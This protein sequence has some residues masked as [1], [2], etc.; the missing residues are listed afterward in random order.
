MMD[1]K[2]MIAP[3]SSVGADEGRSPKTLCT[4]SSIAEN[5]E[6]IKSF[7][8]WQREIRRMADPSYLKTVSMTELF[9][10][11]YQSRPPVI[12]GLLCRGM[13]LF[14][15]APKVGKSFLMGQVAYHVS[16]GTPLWGFPVRQG[17]VLY[18]AL[19]DDYGFKPA[20]GI[21]QGLRSFAEWY[22]EYYGV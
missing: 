18:L 13:Y 9:D 2:R 12:D 21:R 20:I 4:D 10:N 16:T 19:E 22:R 14:V 15:G 6:E 17:T 11:V 5:D 1:E 8:E 7:Q 3:E